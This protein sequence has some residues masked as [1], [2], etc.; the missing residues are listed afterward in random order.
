[1]DLDKNEASAL[2]RLFSPTVLRDFGKY[3]RS[4]LFARLLLHTRFSVS[5]PP[6]TTVGNALDQAFG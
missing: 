3:A 6:E 4:P 2:S 1:M 5:M